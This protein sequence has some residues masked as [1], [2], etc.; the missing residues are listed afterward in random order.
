MTDY[1]GLRSE[2]RVRI[3]REYLNLA[4]DDLNTALRVR[5][6]YIRLGR[7]YGMTWAEIGDALGKSEGAVRMMVNRSEVT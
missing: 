1:I 5:L 7:G 6:H 2:E 3:T 4:R